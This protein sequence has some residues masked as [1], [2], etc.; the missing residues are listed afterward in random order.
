MGVG[1]ETYGGVAKFYPGDW[2]IIDSELGTKLHQVT[3][4]IGSNV[5]LRGHGLGVCPGTVRRA[6]PEELNR[7]LSKLEQL[8]YK[9]T[10]VD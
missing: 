8:I 10:P 5:L 7:M 9:I 6:T 3:T 1:V 4:T 2:V